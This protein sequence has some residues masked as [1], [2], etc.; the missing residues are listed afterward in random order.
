PPCLRSRHQP[1]DKHHR[2]LVR[3]ER[4]ELKQPR[5]M[6]ML[7]RAEERDDIERTIRA[8]GYNHGKWR[9]KIRRQFLL[10]AIN[11]PA[12]A[13]HRPHKLPPRRTPL[14]ESQQRRHRHGH[15]GR[16]HSGFAAQEI[17]IRSKPC[18]AG[19]SQTLLRHASWHATDLHLVGQHNLF[20][21]CRIQDIYSVP[22]QSG[23]VRSRPV[24]F[25]AEPD[26][27]SQ[28]CTV[29][30]IVRFIPTQHTGPSRARR[31]QQRARLFFGRPVSRKCPPRRHLTRYCGPLQL[32]RLG[33]LLRQNPQT[34]RGATGERAHHSE[35]QQQ[36]DHGKKP[37]RPAG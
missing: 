6:Q 22:H 2:R 13:L 7:L 17:R 1:V 24:R 36:T 35:R 15:P 34:H 5:A 25:F 23:R 16:R 31:R 10:T 33:S 9:R 27:L 32:A 26:Q 30:Q 19:Q 12:I 20:R 18:Y 29:N 14:I 3:I 4:L 28:R 11:R 21:R 8:L 37:H